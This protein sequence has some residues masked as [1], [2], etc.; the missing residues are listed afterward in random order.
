MT[1]YWSNVHDH[2]KKIGH[3][4]ED[5][6]ELI[7]GISESNESLIASKTNEIIKVLTIFSAIILPLNFVASIYG[8]NIKLPWAEYEFAFLQ[9]IILMAAMV[10]I[11]LIGFKLKRWF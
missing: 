10:I 5:S 3:R 2:F 1:S 6:Q 8:M 9:L 4:L 11:F 7:E